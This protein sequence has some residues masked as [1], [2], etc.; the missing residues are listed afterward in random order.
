MGVKTRAPEGQAV[1]RDSRCAPD[2]T[3]DVSLARIYRQHSAFVWRLIRSQGFADAT[4][5]DLLH[6]VF[7]VVHRRLHEYDGRAAMTTWL[8]NI[9]RGVTSTHRRGRSREAR[10]LALVQTEAGPA[11]DLEELTARRQAAD[12]VRRFVASLDEDK[13]RVFELSQIDGLPM[14]AVAEICGINVNTAYTRLRAGRLA[15]QAAVSKL[16]RAE[17]DKGAK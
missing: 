17:R 2:E 12:H 8:Y 13:R 6:E 16:R 10:R 9:T 5:E 7:L 3:V 15:F 11:L 14:P 4:A 1:P